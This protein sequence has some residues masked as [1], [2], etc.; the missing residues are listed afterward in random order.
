MSLARA[1]APF[2]G[3]SKPGQHQSN[4]G[5]CGTDTAQP[6]KHNLP[7]DVCVLQCLERASCADFLLP[8]KADKPLW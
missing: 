4:G 6:W 2:D 5:M 3:A 8:H 7:S 1:D